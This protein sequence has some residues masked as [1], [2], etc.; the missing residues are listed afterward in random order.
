MPPEPELKLGHHC[1]KAV[2]KEAKSGAGSVKQG[3]G[4]I[5]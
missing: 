5:T 2:E 3:H 4:F 1:P